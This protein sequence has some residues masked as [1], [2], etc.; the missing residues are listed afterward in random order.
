[1]SRLEDLCFGVKFGVNGARFVV[2]DFVVAAIERRKY[3]RFTE[4]VIL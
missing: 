3:W 4:P 2:F 1:L